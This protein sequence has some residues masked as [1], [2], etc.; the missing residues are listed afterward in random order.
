MKSIP[1]EI[2]DRPMLVQEV[3]GDRTWEAMTTDP[4][5]NVWYEVTGGKI[6]YGKRWCRVDCEMMTEEEAKRL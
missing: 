4:F 2:V 5:C 6:D 1:T 3:G